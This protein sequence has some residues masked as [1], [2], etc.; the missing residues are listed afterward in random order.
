[1]IPPADFKLGQEQEQK[2]SLRHF[3]Y[4]K[5]PLCS[6]EGELRADV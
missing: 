2:L 3:I 1:M 6:I 4:S 5:G